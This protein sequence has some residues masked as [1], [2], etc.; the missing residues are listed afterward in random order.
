[1]K[2]HPFTAKVFVYVKVTLAV[3]VLCYGHFAH[4]LLAEPSVSAPPE[5]SEPKA[6]IRITADRLESVHQQGWV[7]FIGHVQ[8]TQAD[9]VMTADRMRVFYQYKDDSSEEVAKIQ[10]IV[11]EGNV[12][13]VFDN[14][15]RTAE[16]DRAVYEADQQVLELSGGDAKVWSGKNIVRGKKITVFYAE[17]RSVV[18]GA[19][20][21]QVEATLFVKEGN[22]LMK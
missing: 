8:A 1:M 22:G 10:R 4:P 16:A 17:K 7:D 6:P 21:D 19:G 15:T 18:E 13:I 5:E 12:R 3:V 11:S 9:V 2:D 14:E 20:Q